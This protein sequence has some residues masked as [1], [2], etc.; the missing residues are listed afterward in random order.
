MAV[1]F[2]LLSTLRSCARSHAVLQLEILALRHQLQALQRS[3]APR[4]RLAQVDRQL[5]VWLSRVWS[6][7]RDGLMIVKPETVIA[8]H[9]RGF[10][11]FW[12]WKS[13]RPMSRRRPYPRGDGRVGLD[14]LADG[15]GRSRRQRDRRDRAGAQYFTANCVD[16]HSRTGDLS[17]M[18]KKYTRSALRA[19]LLRPG[20][21]SMPPSRTNRVDEGRRQHLKL[22]ER[23]A[24][25]DVR[26]LLDF[27]RDPQ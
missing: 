15:G 18:A 5:W 6:E 8:W 14:A 2:A 3:R 19:R 13:R 1:L 17:G 12:T 23:Y 26:N 25:S 22:L 24:D 11:A 10:R 21:D 9:R 7:W 27:L 20:A 4:L 16:C